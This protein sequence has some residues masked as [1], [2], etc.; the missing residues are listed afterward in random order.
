[1]KKFLVGIIIVLSIVCFAFYHDISVLKSEADRYK[2][3]T[4]TLMQ[5]VGRY[6]TSDSLNAVKV[7][8]LTLELREMESYRAKDMQLIES[9]QVKKRELERITSM[10]MQTIANIKGQVKDSIIYRDKIIG[11]T[12]KAL[13]V[14]DKWIDL[15]GIVYNDGVFDGT[16]EVRDSLT[17]VETV[18]YR[19]FLG[20]LW[21]TKRVKHRA[22]DVVNKCP[23]T[24]ITGLESIVI[25]Q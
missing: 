9:L 13:S 12:I 16:L 8:T 21:K 14:S 24:H 3:N 18:R 5:D 19:R 17:V 2:E 23:Y 15:H 7:S 4:K 1:M 6:R 10:Q 11:D 22:V 20:F 25:E